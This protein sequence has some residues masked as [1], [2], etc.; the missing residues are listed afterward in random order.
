MARKSGHGALARSAARGQPD[1]VDRRLHALYAYWERE[2]GTRGMPSR[3]DID[4][5]ELR[6]VLGHLVLLDVLQDP[7][8]FRIR[9]QGTELEWW[10]GSDLT[11]KTLDH[12]RS[13]A[14]SALAHECLRKVVETRRPL[15]KIGEEIIG[16]LPRR[17]EALLLPLGSDGASVNMVLAA[18]LCREERAQS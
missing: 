16:D 8:R 2:R 17:Y 3:N 4:P 7:L 6:F 18:V 1:L 14:L 13:L 12:L 15:H 10:M 9:L 11:G 5:A